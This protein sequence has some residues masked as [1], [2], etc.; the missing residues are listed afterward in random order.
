MPS[1]LPVSP[2]ATEHQAKYPVELAHTTVIVPNDFRCTL[3]S[4]SVSWCFKPNQPQRIISGLRETFRKR[5]IVERTNKAELRP[6]EQSEKAKSC[7]QNL[8][9]EISWKGHK[10]RNRHKNRIKK[11]VG[12]LG[13]FMSVTWTVT[14]PPREGE[15]AGANKPTKA[16]S[17]TFYQS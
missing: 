5:Y 17:S 6:E 9:N 15:P 16:S 13:W 11:R 14:S 8:W 2:G 3:V 7:G 12:K 1:G 10:D 4:Y